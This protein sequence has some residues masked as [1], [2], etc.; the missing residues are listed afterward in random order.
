MCIFVCVNLG[1]GGP[2]TFKPEFPLQVWPDCVHENAREAECLLVSPDTYF[3][4]A[5]LHTLPYVPDLTHPQGPS[6]CHGSVLYKA[7]HIILT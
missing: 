6:K 1:C 2:Y 3:V 5:E 7:S 4:F